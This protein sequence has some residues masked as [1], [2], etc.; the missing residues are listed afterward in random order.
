MMRAVLTVIAALFGVIFFGD[1]SAQDS[2]GALRSMQVE[3]ALPLQMTGRDIEIILASSESI[4]PDQDAVIESF[5][6]MVQ[7]SIALDIHHKERLL[8]Q[9]DLNELDRLEA[10]HSRS[11]ASL[12]EKFLKELRVALPQSDRW[13]VD[14]LRNRLLHRMIADRMYDFVGELNA[15]PVDVAA[16]LSD[17]TP[18][19]FSAL[20]WSLAAKSDVLA[21]SMAG[22][23][24]QLDMM[25]NTTRKNDDT[26]EASNNRN[27]AIQE[28][29]PKLATALQTSRDHARSLSDS[30]QASLP[31]ELKAAYV[32]AWLES[33]Y[34]YIY[35]PLQ[36]EM[37]AEIALSDSAL[38]EDVRDSL[39]ILAEEFDAKIG[40]ARETARKAKDDSVEQAIQLM[41]GGVS[42]NNA[43]PYYDAV[44][45]IGRTSQEYQERLRSLLSNSV[46]GAYQSRLEQVD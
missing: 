3:L 22:V 44:E 39:K 15:H 31:T 10:E 43:G 32:Q 45:S 18:E 40:H 17:L 41:R 21:H 2:P 16:E 6:T 1:A 12:G 42:P 9:E 37:I 28:A 30:V 34:P 26:E 35:R 7:R 8:H 5:F 13:Q 27:R 14:Q 11:K 36:E 38:D 4:A 33:Q 25:E 46:Y 19:Q 24:E 29:L 20:T 23:V